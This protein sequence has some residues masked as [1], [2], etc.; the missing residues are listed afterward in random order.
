MSSN[1]G[2]LDRELAEVFQLLTPENKQ[3]VIDFLAVFSSEQEE[4]SSAPAS[5]GKDTP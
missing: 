5:T 3:A 1:D 2:D 4:I